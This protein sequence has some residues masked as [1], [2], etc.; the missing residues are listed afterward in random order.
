MPQSLFLI[1]Y[2]DLN[3]REFIEDRELHRFNK[4]VF[5]QSQA[6]DGCLDKLIASLSGAAM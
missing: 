3:S 5:R 6:I 4:D 1:N 2:E